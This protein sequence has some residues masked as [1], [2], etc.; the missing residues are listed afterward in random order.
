MNR[1]ENTPINRRHFVKSTAALGVGSVF[2]RTL[3]G[4]ARAADNGGVVRPIVISSA[5]GLQATAKAMQMLQGGADALDAVI[6]GVNIVE[7][8][9]ND[10][11]VGFGGLPNEDGV[12]ELDASVMHGPTG[13]G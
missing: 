2:G 13:R 8:D 12:V 5:N 11:S 10:H 4:S 1:T 7:D 3:E 6:A 9:P